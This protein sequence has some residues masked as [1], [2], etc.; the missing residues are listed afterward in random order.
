[1][2]K[3]KRGD[4]VI[5]NP[6]SLIIIENISGRKVVN[7]QCEKAG[8]R[9][10]EEYEVKNVRNGISQSIQIKGSKLALPAEHFELK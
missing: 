6:Q 10:G 7:Y 9:I 8:C 1:M 5:Y 4:K 3:F 2:E